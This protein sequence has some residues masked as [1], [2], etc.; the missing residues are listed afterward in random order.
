[1]KV[2]PFVAEASDVYPLHVAAKHYTR[3]GS[4][5]D[6]GVT[7]VLAHAGGM[8]KE[9][10]EPILDRLLSQPE[11]GPGLIV[12]DAWSIDSPN[13]GHSAVLNYEALRTKWLDACTR[14]HT[15]SL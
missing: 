8:H 10:W 5:C 15:F 2:A 13:H 11:D 6:R 3:D 7:L 1:M 9:C 12:K 14:D 4:A